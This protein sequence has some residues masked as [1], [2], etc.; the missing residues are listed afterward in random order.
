MNSKLIVLLCLLA[1]MVPAAQ[2]GSGVDIEEGKWEI[3]VTTEVAGMPM[4]MPPTTFTQCIK[5]DEPVPHQE[6]PN[7]KCKM[8][9]IKT[10]GNTV[11]W[12]MTCKNPGG[13]MIGKG[14]V[15]YEGDKMNGGMDMETQGMKMT[16][17]FDGHR[18]GPC[19]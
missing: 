5:K 2:A 1:F 12:T 3:T 13:D 7:Q 8:S 6:Q 17:K 4:K 16:T 18:V 11:S 19:K 9:D 14:K 15:S 10:E